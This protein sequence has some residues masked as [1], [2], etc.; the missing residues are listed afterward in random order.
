M[1]DKFCVISSNCMSGVWY[2]DIVKTEYEV[3]FIWSNIKLSDMLWLI[4]NFESI[5]FTDI[6]C[7]ISHG[8]LPTKGEGDV[9]VKIE[10]CG[11]VSVYFIHYKEND[12]ESAISYAENAWK[13]RSERIAL[14]KQ[15][16]WVY[17]D[18]SVCT[19]MD[20]NEFLLL[21]GKRTNDIFV[22]FTPNKDVKPLF[23]NT[24]VLPKTG[25]SVDKHTKD[26]EKALENY[27]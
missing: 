3:P 10:L 21:A 4:E 13:R 26:L 14:N 25:P 18:D 27:G 1:E 9:H 12:F 16:V 8:E 6:K 23:E 19:D 24:I 20:L 15:K 5:D 2:R 22:L 17:W 7:L 11:K